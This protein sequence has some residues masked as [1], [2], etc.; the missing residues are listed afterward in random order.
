VLISSSRRG[1]RKSNGYVKRTHPHHGPSPLTLS[2]LTE[3]ERRLLLSRLEKDSYAAEQEKF[4]WEYV[5]QAFLDPLV[6]GFALLFHGFAFVL[7]SLSLFMVFF[8]AL[9]STLCEFELE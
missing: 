4:A 6:W 3:E 5:R 9:P 8:L 1:H 7:Y 2:Q